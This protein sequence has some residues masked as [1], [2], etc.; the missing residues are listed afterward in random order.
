MR[1]IARYGFKLAAICFLAS[2]VLAVVNGFTEPQIKMQKEKEE[3]A[4][5]KEVMP[6]AAVFK[7]KT[8]DGKL[9]YYKAYDSSGK[10]TGFV[11]KTEGKGYSSTIESLTGLGLGLQ[12]TNVK[13]LSQNETPGLGTRVTG[14][15]FLSQ[16]QNKTIPGFGQ[17]DAITGSTISS[18][19]VI[20]SIKEKITQLQSLLN[21][22]IEDAKQ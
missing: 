20:D 15:E 8:Q 18:E 4:A 10:L 19:A 5:L 7:T 3:Q 14:P 17:I 1:E 2:L 13:I 16:F 12:I 11:V 21:N 9:L 22:E 6:E